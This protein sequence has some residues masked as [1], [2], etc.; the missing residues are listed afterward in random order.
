MQ[1]KVPFILNCLSGEKKVQLILKAQGIDRRLIFPYNFCFSDCIILLNLIWSY[2]LNL[3]GAIGKQVLLFEICIS[4]ETWK[5]LNLLSY[6]LLQKQ[7][8]RKGGLLLS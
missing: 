8:P 6:A 2:C 1:K 4:L 5:I 3:E 7:I